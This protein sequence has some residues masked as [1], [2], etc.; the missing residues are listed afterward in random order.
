[1]ITCHDLTPLVLPNSRKA[2][3]R[4]RFWQPRHLRCAT[5]VVAISRYVADQLVS[6]GVLAERIAV[7][8]NG[9]EVCSERITVP[10]SEDLLVLAR[11]DG[12]KNLPALLRALA[13]VQQR[14]PDWGG[15]V[16]IVGRSGRQSQL[17]QHLVR[18]LPRPCHVQFVPSL[19]APELLQHLRQS[20]ALISASVEEGFDYP[21][22]EAKAVG[23]PTVISDIAVHR[24]FHK[25][26]S[27][28]FPP[29][30]DG[31]VLASHLQ[32]L[33]TDQRAWQHLSEAGYHLAQQLSVAV[34]RDR[35]REL[36]SAVASS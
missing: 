4:Y 31:S 10:A 17:L 26:S 11:H 36:I 3:L 21:V 19:D 8:P 15:V 33:R 18:R 28:F 5:R 30:D 22:L 7:V 23:L 16:R 35:I 25:G 27:L 9:I 13:G 2:W 24:E 6:F 29:H 20:L 32:Q 34:Q 1:L 14:L 12:N